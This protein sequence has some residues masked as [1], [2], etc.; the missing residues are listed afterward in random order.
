MSRKKV[1]KSTFLQFFKEEAAEIISP[2]ISEPTE[3]VHPGKTAIHFIESST[4]AEETE[5]REWWKKLRKFYVTSQSD[6]DEKGIANLVPVHLATFQHESDYPDKYPVWLNDHPPE[7]SSE[8]SNL[9]FPLAD[10]LTNCINRVSGEENNSKI[11]RS[12]VRHILRKVLT[13]FGNSDKPVLFSDAISSALDEVVKNLNV[14]GS[15]GVSFEVDIAKLKLEL[16]ESGVL[17]PWSPL[18]PFYILS[19]S[20][21]TGSDVNKR[22]LKK[23][24]AGVLTDLKNLLA[25]EAENYPDAHT[26]HLKSALGTAGE[27]MNPVELSSVLPKTA[28]EHMQPQRINR[29]KKVVR[30]LEKAGNILDKHAVILIQDGLFDKKAAAWRNIFEGCEIIGASGKSMCASSLKSF[31]KYVKEFEEIIIALRVGQLEAGNKYDSDLHSDFFSAFTWKMFAD[32]EMLAFPPVVLIADVNS[33]LNNELQD[34]AQ[35]LTSGY[36][37]KLLLVRQH[38]QNHAGHIA[39][40]NGITRQEPAAMAVSYRNTFVMQSTSLSPETLYR[41][42]SEG[43]ASFAPGLFYVL[44]GNTEDIN[45]SLLWS[46]AAIEGRDFPGFVYNGKQ[47]T[48]WGSRFEIAD[49]PHEENDWPRHSIQIKNGGNK[50]ESWDIL[51]TYADFA[52]WVP[53]NENEFMRIPQSYW[54]D[55][56]VPISD[57]ILLPDED[58]VTRIPYIWM[59]DSD[60]EL[61]KV[62]VSWPVFITCLERLDFWHYI[63][64][65][66][67]INSFHV[68]HALE[69]E[70]KKIRAET[71]QE[72]QEL[73]EAHQ[74]ELD[75][76]RK[77]TAS[78]AMDRLTSVLLD[79]DTD[80]IV[81][82]TKPI[83]SEKD[84]SAEGADAKAE[85][86][87]AAPEEKPGKALEDE[88]EE[89]LTGEPWIETPLCTSCNECT[90][91]NN[92]LF[93][94]NADKMAFITDP[95]AGTFAEMVEA[96]EK[97]PV[98][99]IHPGKPLNPDEPGL[100]ELIKIAEKFN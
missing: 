52:A 16:P 22:R 98:K 8:I 97:C 60:N 5:V 3:Q 77:E 74:K 44:T 38:G 76:V 19:A 99:I 33:I 1:S 83:P 4:Q 2:D 73:K 27:L 46:S 7:S 15:E 84:I 95:K 53:G 90:D 9:C 49:N 14:K 81:S 17:I 51:F 79:I 80:S 23:Q 92:R 43:V 63:Q 24:V 12:N 37:V 42:F 64:D 47:E 86:A 61:H 39:N 62:A 56:L 32:E 34:F 21:T 29:I 28:S 50:L 70:G 57:Y 13:A 55:D 31:K 65:C 75:I 25:V 67:G 66:S 45:R 35:L 41:G 10:L 100:E 36:P 85:Q 88:G 68:N 96:A 59:V 87:V 20:L 72:I 26:E 30:S 18:A 91:I 71:L 69:E 54:T 93:K 6:D 82:S 48:E 40:K 11:L 94:Y 58:K 89:L 78:E